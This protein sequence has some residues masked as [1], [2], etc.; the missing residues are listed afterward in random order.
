MD[1]R[2]LYKIDLMVGY[3]QVRIC[4]KDIPKTAF[5]TKYSLYESLVI[6]FWDDQHAFNFCCPYEFNLSRGVGQNSSHLS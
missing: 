1:Y 2:V 6:E 4:D 5:R 3:N